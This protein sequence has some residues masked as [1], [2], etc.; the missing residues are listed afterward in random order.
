MKFNIY[1][2]RAFIV[3]LTVITPLYLDNIIAGMVKKG[4]GVRPI[5]S[6]GEWYV[7]KK[8]SP[9]A[10]ISLLI[11][12]SSETASASQIHKDVVSVI[13][14]IKILHYSIIVSA[15]TD[16]AWSGSNMVLPAPPPPK[17]V[18][19]TPKPNKSNLN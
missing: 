17:P 6:N 10:V 9:A 15:M 1:Y 3:W 4:Y 11:T 16:C 12:T 13:D 19:P 18:P 7:G 14:T 2:D 5:A 8:D